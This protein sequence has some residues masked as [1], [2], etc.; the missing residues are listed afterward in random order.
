MEKTRNG[1]IG[2]E[3]ERRVRGEFGLGREDSVISVPCFVEVLRIM[4]PDVTAM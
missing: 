3:D 4:M 1:R 2:K